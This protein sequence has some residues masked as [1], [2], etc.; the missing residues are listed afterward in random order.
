MEE[1]PNKA[2]RPIREWN[3]QDRPREMLM[4]RAASEQTDAEVLGVL[5]G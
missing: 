3:E 2:R 1:W 4:S 5:I